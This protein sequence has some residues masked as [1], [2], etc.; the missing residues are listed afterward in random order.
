MIA[1]YPVASQVL[2][3]T[4]P[5]FAAGVI[6]QK[7][8]VRGTLKGQGTPQCK[9]DYVPFEDKVEPGEMLLHFGRRPRLPARLPGGRREER[10]RQRSRSRRSWWS[11]AGL[12]HGLAGR[13]DPDPRAC[14]S[15]IPEVAPAD[16][17]DVPGAS[18]AL[19]WHAGRSGSR[20]GAR[21]LRRTGCARNTRRSAKQQNHTYGANPMGA[22]PADFTKLGAP[23]PAAPAQS[24]APAAGAARP[25][26]E[27]PKPG[28]AAPGG[29][30][31]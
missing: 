17:A 5:D 1:A 19:R 12:Q 22:K 2:L 28:A 29:Q 9:M 30:N 7:T 15:A 27:P 23:P 16:A 8:G 20:T 13:A 3:I 26:V 11:R 21:A 14:T 6:S 4:D 31:R 18:A 10:A 24:P 25:P